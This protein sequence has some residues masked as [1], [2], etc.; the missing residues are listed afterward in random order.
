MQEKQITNKWKQI[1]CRKNNLESSEKKRSRKEIFKQVKTIDV[2]KTVY[3]PG[4][5]EVGKKFTNN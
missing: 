1:W 4:K 3:K 5:N 2:G